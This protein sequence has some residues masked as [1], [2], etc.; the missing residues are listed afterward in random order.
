MKTIS[1][2]S[3]FPDIFN[4]LNYGVTSR[5]SQM[6][7]HLNHINISTYSQRE[8]K[9]IDDRPF[10]GQQGMVIKPNIIHDAISDHRSNYPH[11][12][13]IVP[14]PKGKPFKQSDAK[15][16]SL[17]QDIVFLCA[18]YEG[19][20]QRSLDQTPHES[21]SM[22]DFILSGGELA[23]S[24][25]I[26][27][28]LREAP[29][30]LGNPNSLKHDSFQMP[31]LDHPHYTRPWD[32]KSSTPPA[33]LRTGHHK[34]LDRWRNQQS[35]GITWLHRPELIIGQRLQTEDIEDLMV[36]LTQMEPMNEPHS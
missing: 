2:I 36:Y 18:R 16:L 8:D 34:N 15:R 4:C 17:H 7:I 31:R 6:D 22:G 30:I 25:M 21:F 12:L 23:A 14:D 32:W 9:R 33:I 35:L 27:A 10:G 13:L 5:A 19:F 20:D 1:T 29:G 28:I 24:M 11:A 3:V 26:D